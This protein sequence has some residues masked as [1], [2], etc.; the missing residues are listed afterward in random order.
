M[1][2]TSQFAIISSALPVEK[3]RAS[4]RRR[5]ISSVARARFSFGWSLKMRGRPPA[6]RTQRSRKAARSSGLKVSR[7]SDVQTST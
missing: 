6:M 7:P 1:T 2:S 3:T 5:R 4:G